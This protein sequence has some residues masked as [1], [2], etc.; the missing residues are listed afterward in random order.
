MQSTFHAALLGALALTPAAF[1]PA[2]QSATGVTRAAFENSPAAHIGDIIALQPGVTYAFGNGPRDISISVR[3]SNARS[4]FGVR[5]VQVFE[6]GFPVTQP[7]G[8]ARTDLVD[9]HAYAAIDVAHGPSSALYGNYATGGAIFFRTRAGR[10]LN[11]FEVSADAG[12]D[13]YANVFA[14]F[15]GAGEASD[16]AAF[17]SY[18]RGDGFT[19]HTGYSTITENARATLSLTPRDRLTVK[20]INNDMRADLSIRLSLSQFLANPHQAA[21]DDLTGAACA[22]VSVFANGFNGARVSLSADQAGLKRDDR[23]TIVG[24]RWEHDFDAETTWRSQLVWDNRDINQPTSATSAVGTFPSFNLISDVT[25]RGAKATLFAGAFANYEDINSYSYNLA[26]GGNAALGGLS[27]ATLGTHF[28]AG[29]RARAEITPDPRWTLAFGVGG[30]HTRLKAT[31]SAYTYPAAAAPAISRIAADR[32]FFNVAPEAAV[33]FTP[34]ENW[35]LRARVAAAYGTPQATNLF[36]TPA[37]VPGNNIALDPQKMTGADLGVAF[38]AGDVRVS[39]T[40]FYE[41]FQ[42]ELVSQSAGANLLSYTYNAPRSEHRGIEA[43]GEWRP[44]GFAGFYAS[45]AYLLNDQ[46]YTRYDERLSAGAFS[47]VFDRAGNKIPGVAP[48]TA[49]ARIGYDAKAGA[50]GGWGAFVET[51]WR[52]SA[53]IDNANIAKAP[54]YTLVN[55][56][57]HYDFSRSAG[58]LSG[59]R[60]FVQGQNLTDKTYVSSASNLANS[61]NTTTG[62][63]N[64]LATLQ[65]AT[66]S[67]YAGQ[68]L[69]VIAGVRWRF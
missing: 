25:K 2:G 40:G 21:C 49:T 22:S 4:T 59:V 57:L 50:L 20:F 19:Q 62:A 26:P 7:D 37:G 53:A 28:N 68:P 47:S 65:A 10:D 34:D 8:L 67:I 66:G 52:Q 44:S 45:A 33:T 31:Q 9:P 30:E 61:L 48:Q 14:A 69:S 58:A 17:V 11:G 64:G 12:S 6:D 54:G 27:T 55:A 3:G 39:L 18:V 16:Y 13:G 32:T 15:G 56:N 24:A 38:A 60:V 1:A 42:D 43:S 41:F 5:N 35:T 51:S 23:R 46:I 36:V 29:V 63:Q